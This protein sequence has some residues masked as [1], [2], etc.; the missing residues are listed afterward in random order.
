MREQSVQVE[1][2]VIGPGHP[3]F[4]IA[5]AGTNHGGDIETAIALID[6]AAEAGADCVKFQTFRADALVA[7]TDHPIATLTDKFGRFGKTVHEMFRKAEMPLEWLPRLFEHARSRNLVFLS[8]PFDE[9]S[10]DVLDELGV[11]A[12]KIASYEIVHIPLLRHIARKGKPILLSTGMANLG[13]IEEAISAIRAEG[14]DK[15]ALFHCAIGYPVAF[16]DVHLAAMDTMRSAFRVPVGF[17][18]H[19]LGVP[20]P[21]AAVARGADLIEKHFTLDSGQDGPDHDFAAEPSTLAEM[22]NGIRAVQA[23]IG[24]P[25]KDVQ[26]S[27]ELHYRRGRRSLFSVVDIPAG[28]RI[29]PEMIAVLRPGV[30]LKP[31][32]FDLVVGRPARRDIRAFQPLSWDD[33]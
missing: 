22:V 16:E 1:N 23:S 18:D 12:F 4:V 24:N 10:A 28:Q 20:V 9:G 2:R 8:T 29:T 5:E 31:K 15:I 27:E 33:V 26:P 3:C 25:T 32:Y 6:C 14:N 19:S 30:G 17:S 11:A 7:P 21:L 13:E